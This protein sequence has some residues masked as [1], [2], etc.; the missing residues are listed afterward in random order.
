V[1]GLSNSFP[2]SSLSKKELN[3]EDKQETALK[4]LSIRALLMIVADS[5]VLR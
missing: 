2:A 4:C 1:G 5:T 3:Q